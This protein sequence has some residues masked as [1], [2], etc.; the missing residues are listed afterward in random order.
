MT[1]Y[2][3]YF[4]YNQS[5]NSF[6][7]LQIAEQEKIPVYNFK[8]GIKKAFCVQSAIAID[9]SRIETEREQKAL[10][11]EELGHIL[12]GALY[13]LLQCGNPLYKQNVLRQ[14]RRARDRS[15]RLQVPLREL[16]T[17]IA[18]GIDDYEIADLLDID[19]STLQD[20]VTYYKRKGLM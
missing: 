16:K 19:L 7:L 8:T 5:M 13:P 6:Q 3:N 11:A 4:R 12:S 2:V 20:A 10:L 9:F 17:A 14:E 1:I 15:L 18:H